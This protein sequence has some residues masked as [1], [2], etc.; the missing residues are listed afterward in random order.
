MCL[1]LVLIVWN[2]GV[3][4]MH[5]RSAL[6]SQ[7]LCLSAFIRGP[8]VVVYICRWSFDWHDGDSVMMTSKYKLMWCLCCVVEECLSQSGLQEA[9]APW[10]TA[11]CFSR[12]FL[13]V[14]YSG[15][16]WFI[17]YFHPSI[18]ILVRLFLY[19]LTPSVYPL[20][21][22]VCVVYRHLINSSSGLLQLTA[23]ATDSLVSN[24][25]LTSNI[26]NIHLIT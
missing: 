21:P 14:F 9:G 18:S 15:C 22:S 19:M 17:F 16:L 10:S 12:P 7:I 1:V 25:S 8:W 11:T 20:W 5:C 26:A 4:C 2:C 23:A 13:P 24:A 3:S 6:R